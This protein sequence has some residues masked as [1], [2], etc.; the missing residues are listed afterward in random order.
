MA[1]EVQQKGKQTE[2]NRDKVDA[3]SKPGV[4]EEHFSCCVPMILCLR[5][6]MF[7]HVVRENVH[8]KKG[9]TINKKGQ[10]L[11][12]KRTTKRK[13]KSMFFFSFSKI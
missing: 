4:G 9:R 3:V 13:K 12:K 8:L 5:P 11:L 10:R 7:L 1:V 2:E 6:K